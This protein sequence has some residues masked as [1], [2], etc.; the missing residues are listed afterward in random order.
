[1]FLFFYHRRY[2]CDWPNIFQ[3]FGKTVI[4]IKPE[5]IIA[6]TQGGDSFLYKLAVK[7]INLHTDRIS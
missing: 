7:R 2:F 6:I 3:I 5:N 1:M 4:M